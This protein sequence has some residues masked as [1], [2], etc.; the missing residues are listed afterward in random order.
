MMKK[1]VARQDLTIEES[2]WQYFPSIL[3]SVDAG[4]DQAYLVVEPGTFGVYDAHGIDVINVKK[5]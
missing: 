2:L 4:N 1:W 5:L 3:Q